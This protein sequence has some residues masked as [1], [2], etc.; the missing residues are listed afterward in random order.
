MGEGRRRERENERHLLWNDNRG[1]KTLKRERERE[2]R[3]NPHKGPHK[4][5][6]GKCVCVVCSV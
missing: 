2:R 6:C 3:K 4:R 1:K 5:M